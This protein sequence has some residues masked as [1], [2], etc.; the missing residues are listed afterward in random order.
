MGDMCPVL[1]VTFTGK[2]G[3]LNR[4]F[5]YISL[6]CLYILYFFNVEYCLVPCFVLAVWYVG[7]NLIKSYYTPYCPMIPQHCWTGSTNPSGFNDGLH[8][9]SA[10]SVME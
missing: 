5:L 3:S 6:Y 7:S 9:D 1:I 2:R 8:Q 10:R 4:I